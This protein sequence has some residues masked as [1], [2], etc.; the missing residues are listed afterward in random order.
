MQT[1]R[2]IYQSALVILAAGTLQ[3]QPV[4]V[5]D[6]IPRGS[7]EFIAIGDLVYFRSADSLY[8][9]DGTGEGTILLKKVAAGSFQEFAGDLYF[10]GTSGAGTGIWRSDGTAAGTTLLQTYDAVSFIE[11]T[12]NFLYFAASTAATGSEIYRTDGTPGGTILLKDINPGPANGMSNFVRVG[13]S[14]LFFGANNGTHGIELWKT[15]GTP[16]GTVMIK[17]INPGAESGITTPF[18]AF[19]NNKLFFTGFTSAEGVNPWVSDGSP[20]GTMLL[21]DVD[22]SAQ[23]LTESVDY[24]ADHDGFLYFAALVNPEFFNDAPILQLWKTDGSGPGTSYIANLCRQCGTHTNSL[25]YHDKLYFFLK[26]IQGDPISLWGTDGTSKGTERIYRNERAR[27]PFFDVVNDL[28]LFTEEDDGF[29]SSIARSDG[30][31]AGTTSFWGFLSSED[32]Y[33]K[34]IPLVKINNLV[35]FVDHDGSRTNYGPNA[36]QL[37]QTDGYTVVSLRTL[38]GIS[39]KGTDNIVNYNGKVVFTTEDIDPD[40]PDTRK[41]LWIYDPATLP[42]QDTANFTLVNADTDEDIQILT[43]GDTVLKPAATFFNI[44]YNPVGSP[45]SVVFK[46]QDKFVRIESD[47]PF[48]LRGDYSGNYLPWQAGVAGSHKVEATPYSGPRGTGIAG[49]TITINFTIEEDSVAC[50]ASGTILR[51]FWAA[52]PGARIEHIPL[53]AEP[54]STSELTIFEGPENIGKN[55][56]ARVRGFIC[57]PVTGDYTFW[58]ASN[59]HSELWLSTNDNPF[60]KVR[61]AYVTGATG[62]RQWNKFATQRSA[63]IWLE[64]GVSYYIEALHKQG[65]GTDHIAVGWQLPDGTLE[66]PIP[67]SRLSPFTAETTRVTAFDGES[68]QESNAATSDTASNENQFAIFPNP[69]KSGFPQLMITGSGG[70]SGPVGGIEIQRLTGEIVYVTPL[71]CQGDCRNYHV[72]V[73][74]LLSP[75]V[76]LV[77]ITTSGRRYTKRLLVK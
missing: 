57:P 69:A 23:N 48:A 34:G 38:T 7:T 40:S 22:R 70:K 51:D 47:P 1:L 5:K 27:I 73:D 20:E 39:F 61:I 16:S 19:F 53:G 15:D 24:L 56:A 25:V 42:P 36:F 14:Y 4:L 59:D 65:V 37:M 9:T 32:R 35:Y 44:R 45:G 54:T 50:A 74:E 63:P 77:N 6:E 58:I 21:T 17:D 71:I 52:V 2:L 33:G 31:P 55:Y 29:T 49:R 76:Y 13:G 3:A 72:Q 26:E 43:E 46:H 67:G 60:D 8:R 18:S 64:Q 66:R 62:P 10:L 75:G 68:T 28:I 12:E 11:S 41:K 30:T